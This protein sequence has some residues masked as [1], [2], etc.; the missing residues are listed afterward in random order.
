MGE[1]VELMR[2]ETGEVGG[3]SAPPNNAI[4]AG[5]LGLTLCQVRPAL[6]QEQRELPVHSGSSRE[7]GVSFVWSGEAA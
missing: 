6:W 7:R 2:V 1:V 4:V 3:L 5:D